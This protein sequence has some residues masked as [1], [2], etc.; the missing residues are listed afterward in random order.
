MA[1]SLEVTEH[2]AQ[3]KAAEREYLGMLDALLPV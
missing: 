1:P 2:P 3:Q